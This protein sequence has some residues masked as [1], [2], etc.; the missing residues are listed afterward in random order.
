MNLHCTK[1]PPVSERLSQVFSNY[2]IKNNHDN[3][4]A[5]QAMKCHRMNL[6]GM[7]SNTV[8]TIKKHAATNRTVYT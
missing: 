7:I 4:A 2:F 6:E 3:K 5:I 8:V 1:P